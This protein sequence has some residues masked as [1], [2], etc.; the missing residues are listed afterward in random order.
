MIGVLPEH[1]RVMAQ[2]RRATDEAT[3]EWARVIQRQKHENRL[4][5]GLARRELEAQKAARRLVVRRMKDEAHN[6]KLVYL[7]AKAAGRRLI[8][9]V[10]RYLK[11]AA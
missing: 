10:D 3:S 9:L 5:L 4:M 2:V 7:Q 6:Y 11:K 1:R 8:P